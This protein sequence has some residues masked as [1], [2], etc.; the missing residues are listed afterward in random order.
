MQVASHLRSICT[1]SF[2][3]IA[4]SLT[5][6]L[7]NIRFYAV[8]GVKTAYIRDKPHMNIGTIGHVDHGKTTLTA[9][10]TKI[11]SGKNNSVYRSYEEID[12]APEERKRGITINA[13]VVDYSTSNRHYAHTDCPGHADYIK[14]MITGANQMECAILVVAATDGTM[15][16]TREHLL[17]AKQIGIERLVVFINKADVADPEMLE[18][19]ELEVRDTL[20]HYGFDGDNTPIVSGSALCALENRD[21][22]MGI[23]KIEELLDAI[24]SVPMPKREKDKP[25]LLPIEHVFTITGRGTVVTGRI[26]RGILKLQ[27][28]IEIIGYS[29][30]L[31]STVTGIEMFHQLLDQ[32][33]PGDQVG[34]LMRGVKRDE[35]RRGQFVVEP[36]SMSIH[37]Y[38][39]C[40]VYML[41]K[42]EGG[43]AKPFTGNHQFHVF[44]KS[45]D[46]PAVL[47]L[48][49]GKEMVMPGEDAAVNLHFHRKMA[50]EVGQR[51]T[52]RASSATIGYGV[53]GKILPGPGP[54][55]WSK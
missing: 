55:A 19:V 11:L 21:P 25:F 41:S 12:A 40:Q 14:N 47:V 33:E 31:K 37:D 42:K 4:N 20:K 8:P 32:A 48:P 49:E 36:K 15:P 10:I 23:E 45:W 17:L 29:Q 7:Q 35:V 9:A 43:R 22:K 44:S 50:L 46:C 6:P 52:I 39:Q 34:I 28:P 13:A 30:I 18:L 26:E 54:F 24:D 27:S 51:F 16:Q 2:T 1:L 5:C 38:V 3:K 53:V